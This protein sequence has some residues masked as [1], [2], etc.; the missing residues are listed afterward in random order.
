M[1]SILTKYE[2]KKANE[3]DKMDCL[4]NFYKIFFTKI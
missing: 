1:L 4:R 2:T 3:V